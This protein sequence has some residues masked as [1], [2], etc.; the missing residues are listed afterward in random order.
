MRLNPERVSRYLEAQ[1]KINDYLL[2]VSTKN[3]D[4]MILFSEAKYFLLQGEQKLR[5]LLK[6]VSKEN[7]NG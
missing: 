2:K 4:A 1:K 7:L 5:D 3:R 6:I